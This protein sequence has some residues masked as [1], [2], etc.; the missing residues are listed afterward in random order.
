MSEALFGFLGVIIGSF[1]PIAFDIYKRYRLK[2]KNSEYLAI[3]VICILDEFIDKCVDV[4]RDNGTIYGQPS[5]RDDNGN[6]YYYPQVE[7]PESLELPQNA[8]WKMLD[9]DFMYQ[10]LNFPNLVRSTKKEFNLFCEV[11]ACL[12]DLSDIYEY[13]RKIYARLGLNAL[14]LAD[15]LRAKYGLPRATQNK[16]NSDWSPK[17]YFEEKIEETEKV[18]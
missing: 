16:C 18:I 12:P 6:V 9:G 4:I 17:K 11:V 7:P 1:I 15:K 5:E 14:E 13:R 8:D 2:K 3:Q 10:I